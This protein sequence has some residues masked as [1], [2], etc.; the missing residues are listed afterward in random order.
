MNMTLRQLEILAAAADSATFSAAAKHL[1][2]SQP[3]LSEAIRRVEDE[4]PT[5][6]MPNPS[7]IPGR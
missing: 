2:I 6:H 7:P 3:A 1:G 4:E 5:C